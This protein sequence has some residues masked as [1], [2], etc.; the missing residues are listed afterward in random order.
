MTICPRALHTGPLRSGSLQQRD[1]CIYQRARCV[2]SGVSRVGRDGRCTPMWFPRFFV[3]VFQKLP[4]SDLPA[5]ST[6]TRLPQD[7]VRPTRH[8]RRTLFMNAYRGAEERVSP[9]KCRAL[10]GQGGGGESWPLDLVF[11][12]GFLVP[13]SLATPSRTLS[14]VNRTSPVA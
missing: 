3:C 1:R 10:C 11:F 2:G 8:H 9:R 7:Q 4:A 5:P 14:E 6:L 12:F 13:F